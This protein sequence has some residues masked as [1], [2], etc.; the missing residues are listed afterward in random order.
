[1]DKNNKNIEEEKINK[2]KEELLKFFEIIKPNKRFSTKDL[3]PLDNK[4][5]SGYIDF[6]VAFG[7]RKI[8]I[9]LTEFYRQINGKSKLIKLEHACEDFSDKLNSEM[10]NESYGG[11]LFLKP[12]IK[13]PNPNGKEFTEFL[14]EL[15]NLMRNELKDRNPVSFTNIARN[16]Y[17]EYAYKYPTLVKYLYGVRRSSVVKCWTFSLTSTGSV[18]EFMDNLLM[19]ISKKDKKHEYYLKHGDFNETW[20]IILFGNRFSQMTPPLNHMKGVDFQ[21]L[22]NHFQFNRI[23]LY[24][25]SQKKSNLV[26]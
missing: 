14:N 2:G 26:N 22:I 12:S 5:S 10:V 11:V 21:N 19:Y 18:R 23:Y 20:L 6:E 16:L 17:K 8:G 1:M 25:T 13:C 4:G 7:N 15:S 9:E 24:F 3:I